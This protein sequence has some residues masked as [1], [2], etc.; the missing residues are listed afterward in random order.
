MIG[1][2]MP[3]TLGEVMIRANLRTHHEERG[4]QHV[5]SLSN[6]GIWENLRIM[7]EDRMEQP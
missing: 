1:T 4:F 7:I 5:R 2:L 3:G 6:V